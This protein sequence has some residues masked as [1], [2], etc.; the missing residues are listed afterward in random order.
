[1]SPVA[2]IVLLYI[3]LALWLHRSLVEGVELELTLVRTCGVDVDGA[4]SSSSS[5][6]RSIGSR[7]WEICGL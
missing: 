7:S 6:G 5:S 3:L 2:S 4:L 1:M